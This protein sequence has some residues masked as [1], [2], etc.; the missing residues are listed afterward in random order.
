MCIFDKLQVE[1]NRKLCKEIEA[2]G[3][4]PAIQ[5]MNYGRQGVTLYTGK[6]VLAPSVVKCKM[7]SSYDPNYELKEMTL[8]DIERVKNDYVNSACLAAEAGYKIIQLHACHGSLMCSFL[9]PYTNKRTDNY[10]GSYNNRCR[11]IVETIKAIREKLQNNIVIDIRLS[12]DEFT[13]GGLVP[14][15]YDEFTPLIE[16]AGV[17]MMNASMSNFE[18]AYDLFAVKPEPEAKYV[19]LA[20][21][22]KK[23]TSLPIGHAGFI[24]TL[25]KGEE[26]LKE[27]K[28]DLVGYGRMQFADNGF[29]RKSVFGEKID[30][31]IWCAKCLKDLFDQKI[32]CVYCSVNQKYKEPANLRKV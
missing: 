30:R 24:K 8:D 21:T 2:R 1:S 31:C 7:T 17:D 22:L 23:N 11:F 5:L 27:G 3:A 12:I 15:D 19:Y 28:L 14:S 13:E 32:Q 16:K 10:G 18:T 25:E 9:S 26:L 29:V 6:P 4:I 20:E